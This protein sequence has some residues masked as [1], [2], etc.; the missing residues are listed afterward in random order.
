MHET[1]PRAKAGLDIE[2]SSGIQRN[3]L[4]K[5]KCHGETDKRRRVGDLH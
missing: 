5:R 1:A 2:V 4:R 3:T